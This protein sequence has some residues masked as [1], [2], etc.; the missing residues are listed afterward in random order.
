MYGDFLEASHISKLASFVPPGKR[1]LVSCSS[2]DMGSLHGEHGNLKN[3]KEA[4]EVSSRG[5]NLD[6][7]CNLSSLH[8]ERGN[9]KEAMELYDVASRGS[10]NKAWFSYEF[11]F[12]LA[13]ARKW[14]QELTAGQIWGSANAHKTKHDRCI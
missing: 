6:A 8:A 14:I 9:L 4:C 10:S 2:F 5:R 7:T 1:L 13:P 12:T 11:R 3:A